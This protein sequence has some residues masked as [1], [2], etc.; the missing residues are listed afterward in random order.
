MTPRCRPKTWCLGQKMYLVSRASESSEGPMKLS[1]FAVMICSVV[2]ASVCAG[3][4]AAPSKKHLLVLGE[5]HG[6]RHQSVSHAMATIERLG[7]ET[8]VWD[9]TIRTDTELLTKK[10]L[11][12]N[13]KNLN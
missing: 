5:E 3:Q 6:Y 13:A 7:K 12:Y 11:E 9:T 2:A 1:R 10:K 4:A 8:G